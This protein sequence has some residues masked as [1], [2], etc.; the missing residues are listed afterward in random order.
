MLH[1]T[2][3]MEVTYHEKDNVVI[4][5]NV[6]DTNQEWQAFGMLKEVGGG[7]REGGKVQ[8]L[9][10]ILHQESDNYVHI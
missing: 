7:G 4:I 1:L 2:R 3:R 5:I 6:K 9:R 8:G 10:L